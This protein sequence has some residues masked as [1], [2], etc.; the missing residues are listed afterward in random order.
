[1]VE[2]IL[3]AEPRGFCA[4]VERAVETVER[5]LTIY[6]T[7]VYVRHH[8]VHNE[9]VIHELEQK[10]AVFVD[11]LGQVPAGNLIIFSAHGTSPNVKEEAAARE[12]KMIDATCPLVT[13]V[14]LEALRYNRD[15]YS[16]LLIGHKKH[17]EVIGTMGY[18]PMILIE[19]VADAEKVTLPNHDKVAYLTQTTLSVDDTRNIIAA[20]CR[21]FPNIRAPRTDDICYATQNRQDSVKALAERAQLILVLGDTTSSN[22]NRLVETAINRGVQAHLIPDATAIDYHWMDEV[23]IIGITAGASALEAAVQETIDALKLRYPLA[24]V[25]T[26]TTTT[27][28]MTFALP[29]EVDV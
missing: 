26:I 4:G 8:I 5:A 23:H 7:P 14:H 18:A 27:E 25:E 13:K 24:A 2:K 6:G 11:T 15:G 28:D 20:L 16:L 3:L 22:S 1:M 29:K 17:Q 21:R 19:T 12:L 10:G 9:R